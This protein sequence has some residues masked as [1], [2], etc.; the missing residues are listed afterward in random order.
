[1]LSTFISLLFEI[2]VSATGGF[3]DLDSRKIDRHIEEL[4]RQEWF[5]VYY[6]DAK[7]RS[8]FFGNVNVR[9]K[10]QSRILVKRMLTSD[11]AQKSFGHYLQKQINKRKPKSM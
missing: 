7:Y 1:M 2:A 10:L 9:K 6:T 3:S 8:L 5:N 11:K 4:E